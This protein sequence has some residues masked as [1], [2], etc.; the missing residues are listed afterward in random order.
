MIMN[1]GTNCCHTWH[2]VAKYVCHQKL[3][4]FNAMKL[5][6]KILCIR[7]RILMLALLTIMAVKLITEPIEEKLGEVMLFLRFFMVT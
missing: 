1:L 2:K 7:E 5:Y 3:Q 4:L 6:L